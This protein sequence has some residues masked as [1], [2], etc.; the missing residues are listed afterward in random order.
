ML[1]CHYVVTILGM[2]CVTVT[3]LGVRCVTVTLLGMLCV[4]VTLLGMRCVT[5][6]VQ[7]CD[8]R[9]S[10]ASPDSPDS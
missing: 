10:R 6:A 2:Q 8:E 3:I 9:D 4:T 7:P 1:Y 5:P